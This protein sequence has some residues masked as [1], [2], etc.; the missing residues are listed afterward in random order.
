VRG[1]LAAPA[2]LAAAGRAAPLQLVT[3]CPTQCVGP[4]LQPV[5]NA[6]C[7]PILDL[8]TGAK[9]VVPNKGK[10]F[11]DVR[12]TAAAHAAA[13]DAP[14]D[15]G[16]ERVLMIAGSVSWRTAAD[17]LRATLPGARVPTAVEPGPPPFPQALASRRVATHLGVVFTPIEDSLRDCA[18]SLFAKGFLDGVIAPAD[19]S[20]QLPPTAAA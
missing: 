13:M 14:G 10:C 3:I 7:A 6:S 17:V 20:R 12:D 18:L 4:L 8:L 16:V 11:V 2:A 5:L 15:A 19:D 9:A 1:E